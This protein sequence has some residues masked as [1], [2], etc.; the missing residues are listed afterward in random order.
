MQSNGNTSRPSS[1]QQ[2][3][4]SSNSN[5]SPSSAPTSSTSFLS[6]A[7]YQSLFNVDTMD[8]ASRILKVFVPYRSDFFASLGQKGPDCYG[9]FWV[10][11]TLIF[12][13]ALTANLASYSSFATALA[14]VEVATDTQG[15]IPIPEASGAPVSSLPSSSSTSSDGGPLSS[16]LL[17]AAW[18]GDVSS[19]STAAVLVFGYQLLSIISSTL[20]LQWFNI[21]LSLIQFICLWGYGLTPFIPVTLLCSIPSTFLRLLALLIGALLSAAFLVLSIRQ[22]I[23]RILPPPQCWIALGVIALCPCLFALALLLFYAFI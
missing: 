20:V 10:G 16:K 7:F 2:R 15:L 3:G 11:I 4:F 1:S 14:A 19:L 8:V 18:E 6:L 13:L 12:L 9:P 21:D 5:P 23:M 22:S 17:Q